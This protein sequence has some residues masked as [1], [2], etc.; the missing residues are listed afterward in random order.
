MTTPRGLR[1]N[2]PGNIKISD[3]QWKGLALPQERTPEQVGEKVFCVFREMR[4]GVR[5]MAV[6]L[7]RYGMEDRRWNTIK[8][9][10]AHYAPGSDNNDEAAYVKAVATDTG[11]SATDKLD[12]T[13]RETLRKLIMGMCKVENGADAI[14]AETT[15]E[16]D[17]DAGLNLLFDP[18][19]ILPAKTPREMT[20]A[21]NRRTAGKIA[22]GIGFALTVGLIDQVDADKLTTLFT[23]ENVKIMVYFAAMVWG[24]VE[25]AI[26]N[27]AKE[28]KT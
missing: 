1:N 25:T 20:I 15:F 10:I 6:Q 4:Y 8:K 2:N 16:K 26:S 18:D 13:D 27:T 5:A 14:K 24:G 28:R 19:L 17:V 23:E 9:I 3:D 11:F 21:S 22:A 12:L 7:R